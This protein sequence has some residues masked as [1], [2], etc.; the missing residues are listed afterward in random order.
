MLGVST[1]VVAKVMRKRRAK[2]A[3]ASV[4]TAATRTGSARRQ[5]SST[6]K[7]GLRLAG[8]RE[9][10]PKVAALAARALDAA[11]ANLQKFAVGDAVE[12]CGLTSEKGRVMNAKRGVITLKLKEKGRFE[13]QM[14][15]GVLINLKPSNLLKVEQQVATLT[16]T[17]TITL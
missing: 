14:P 6:D 3:R 9:T 8:G 15:D 16:I 4:A 13:I 11:A 10:K 2:R 12:V 5:R 7:A 1:Y 17:I